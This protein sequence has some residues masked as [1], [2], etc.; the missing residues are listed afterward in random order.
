MTSAL[1]RR[2]GSCVAPASTVKR[3]VSPK[4]SMIRRAVTSGLAV[5]S[6]STYPPA[7]RSSSISTTPS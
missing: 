3:S 6:A 4:C 5:A 1:V 7:T 2:P